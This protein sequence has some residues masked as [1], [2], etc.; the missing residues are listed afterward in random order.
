M[1][2]RP[3]HAAVLP[4]G[5]EL[6]SLVRA[7]LDG[8]PA[9]LPIDP[10]LPA[11]ARN[12]LIGTLCPAAVVTGAGRYDLTE[13]VP[14]DAD[15]AVVIA[16]SG[17]TGEP[18]GVELTAAALLYSAGA[19]LDRVGARPGDR[20]LCCL[21]TSHVGGLQVL[22]RSVVAGTEPVLVERF[23]VAAVAAVVEA[24]SAEHT[25]LVP[26]TL[27]RFLDAGVDLARFRSV[28]V[29]GAALSRDLLDRAAGAGVRVISTYGMTE[30]AG[31]C[32]YAGRPL[33]GVD[34]SVGDDGRIRITGPLLAR[35]YRLRPDLTAESFVAGWLVTPDVGLLGTDG[36]L[37]VLG[38]ADDVIVSG[39]VNV[40][41]GAVAD[42]LAT[43]PAVGHVSVIGRPDAEW[44]QRVVAIVV[45]HDPAAPPTLAQLRAHVTA[46]ATPAAAP[47]ELV[48]VAAL[49]V[50]PS[51]KIDRRALQSWRT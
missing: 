1:A 42:L 13:G 2:G 23:S 48:L 30:T 29:G 34:V 22:V 14:V 15:V 3:L 8:G 26:T 9:I 43:H 10:G 7:A 21:P 18:K 17:S 28:L 20:W 4:T 45:P 16:T 19:A 25:A 37:E 6:L 41:A 44:G 39:G 5:P 12:R 47:R 27:R 35:G 51:G 32:V 33:D 24:G 40:A 36:R 38:R 11:A 46:A 49:P 50:L 31:G